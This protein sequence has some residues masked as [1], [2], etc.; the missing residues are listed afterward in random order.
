ME[1]ST[2]EN[3]IEQHK[4]Q[5]GKGSGINEHA[6]TPQKSPPQTKS[7]YL[8]T[9]KKNFRGFQQTTDDNTL[10]DPLLQMLQTRK[11]D[12]EKA[13]QKAKELVETNK[14]LSSELAKSKEEATRFRQE[15]EEKNISLANELQMAKNQK[16]EVAYWKEK[17]ISSCK[18]FKENLAFLQKQHQDIAEI[19]STQKECQSKQ[20]EDLISQ[21]KKQLDEIIQEKKG[22]LEAFK[23]KLN[24]LQEGITNFAEKYKECKDELKPLSKNCMSIVESYVYKI[25]RKQAENIS[26]SIRNITDALSQD[27]LLTNAE[28]VSNTQERLSTLCRTISE[29]SALLKK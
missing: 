15:L 4:E 1:E 25:Q 18:L 19:I 2:E 10:V 17:L 22:K 16:E 23:S 27:M 12:K 7:V 14:H 6:W 28:I 21:H 11:I 24:T 5:N 3:K 20:I 8:A 29:V 26:I 9:D 13:E